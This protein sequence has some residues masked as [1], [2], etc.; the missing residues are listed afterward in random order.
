MKKNQSLKILFPWNA[1]LCPNV[2]LTRSSKEGKTWIKHIVAAVLSSYFSGHKIS[3]CC[4]NF[5]F[6]IR[7]FSKLDKN[8]NTRFCGG[9]GF[10]FLFFFVKSSTYPVSGLWSLR[11]G[12][13]AKEPKSSFLSIKL[14]Q[15][16]IR[17]CLLDF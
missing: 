5:L 14:W 7:L 17:L 13:N 3:Y 10:S 8:Y 16:L 1:S 12:W 4:Y 6:Q 2:C 9:R 11:G 15:L